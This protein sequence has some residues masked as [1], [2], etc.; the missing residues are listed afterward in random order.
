MQLKF[1][2]LTVF[3][4]FFFKWSYNFSDRFLI[5]W[6]LSYFYIGLLLSIWSR[7]FHSFSQDT[8]LP[9]IQLYLPI[10]YIKQ[11][12]V[13]DA[14]VGHF[15]SKTNTWQMSWRLYPFPLVLDECNVS[16]D[17]LCV[18][19]KL[20]HSPNEIVWKNCEKHMWRIKFKHVIHIIA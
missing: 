1:L 19:M 17:D 11:S 6:L 18:E 12:F 16:D 20:N 14:P 7:S 10:W 15:S 9:I 4:T 13:P 8:I 2:F 5:P 3:I